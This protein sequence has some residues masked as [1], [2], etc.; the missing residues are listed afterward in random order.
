L[1]MSYFAVMETPPLR[2]KSAEEL[3]SIM[4]LGALVRL[5]QT[6]IRA[7]VHHELVYRLKLFST[8]RTTRGYGSRPALGDARRIV[9][10]SI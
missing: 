4:I 9:H 5:Y 7:R 10:K 2:F 6:N 1:K 8:C 3:H